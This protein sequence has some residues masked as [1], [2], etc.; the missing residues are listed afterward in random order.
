MPITRDEL[1]E[2]LGK[3]RNATGLT[4][5]EVAEELGIS[6]SAIAQIEG[7]SRRVSGLELEHLAYLYGREMKEFFEEEPR[8][9]GA[10][11]ALFR[12]EPKM[13]EDR[14]IAE[15]LRQAVRIGHE[16][17]S[18]EALL[19]I[20]NGAG[21]AAAYQVSF[22][23]SRW[24]AIVQG[25]K[26]AEEER[27]RLGLGS[28]PVENLS[29]LLEAEGV[30]TAW[31]DLPDDVSGMTLRDESLGFMVVVN[32]KHVWQRRRFSYA[33]EY[34][35][36][37]LD[38]DKLENV[39]RTSNRR[40]LREVRANSFAAS[41]LMPEDGIADFLEG[42][43]K[44]QPSRGREEIFDEE[45]ALSAEG[46]MEPG[47][48][49]I[50]LYDVTLLAHH[51][52][53]SRLAMLYRLKNL[54]HLNAQELEALKAAEEAGVGKRIQEALQMPEPDPQ[55]LRMEFKLRFVS[56]A[57][58]ALRRDLISRS[59]LED[60]A[61][62]LGYSASEIDGILEDANIPEDEPI[63]PRVAGS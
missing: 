51:F 52:K 17:T 47:S 18:L 36:V 28:L 22:P 5:Q 30:R 39:S 27:R 15:T 50:Q 60:V 61:E 19:G 56:L 62:L 1:G 8:N 2:R 40:E 38:R 33:H 42:L 29:E 46:R 59:K 37:L 4:Q 58:E 13:A 43:A 14:E 23:S 10:L 6:R 41:F 45:E 9:R 3:A 53:V 21:V 20:S 25:A 34:A 7:G 44:G 54:K 31:I 55:T 35:H 24:R 11:A 48:Q 63:E 49:D 32:L 57:V 16:L 26:T 12:A